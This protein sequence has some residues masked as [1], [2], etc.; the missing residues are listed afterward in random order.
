MSNSIVQVQK[1]TV[2]QDKNGK[3]Y[4]NVLFSTFNMEERNMGGRKIM[5][6][7]HSK[8]S[9]F[10]A[11]EESYLDSKP[12]YGWDAK[13]GDYLFVAQVTRDVEPYHIPD[14]QTGELREINSYTARIPGVEN[15]TEAQIRAAFKSAGMTLLTEDVV[16]EQSEQV[17]AEGNDNLPY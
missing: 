7:T 10:N 8:T 5:I 3:N 15:P 16:V 2:K 11:Y 1:V 14:Q 9:S 6:K 13:E 4:K 17:E 12:E